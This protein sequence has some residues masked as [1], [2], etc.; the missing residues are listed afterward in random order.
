[1][2]ESINYYLS[3]DDN[4]YGEISSDVLDSESYGITLNVSRVG[5]SYVINGD[6]AQ[7]TYLSDKF[8]V[9]LDNIKEELRFIANYKFDNIVCCLSE[10]Q[11]GVYLD[12]KVHDKD[13]AY[14]TAGI[15]E[16]TGDYSVDE[17]K[18]AIHALIE[19]HPILKGRVLDTGYLPLL[20]CDSYP[21]ISITNVDDYSTLTRPFDLG[22]S[23]ARFFIVDNKYGMFIVYDMHHIISDATSRVIINRD[24]GLA[25]SGELD[26]K[27]D[28]G[29]VYASRDSFDSQFKPDYD[30]A[31]GFF[32]EMFADIDEVS[33]LLDDVDGCAGSVSLPIRGVREDILSFV[34]DKGITVSSFLNAVFAY[35]Y[36]RFIGGNKVYYTFTVNGRHEDYSQDAL[37]M[38]VRT[39]PILVDCTNASVG[40][41]LSGVSNLI[42][43]SMGNSVYPFRLLASEFG[44]SNSVSF[45]YN[46]DLNDTT[47][48]GDEIVFSDG[49]DSVSDLLCF[50]NDLDDGFL[51]SLN[52]DD[53]IS[54]DTAERFVNVFKEIL[55]QLL[56][57]ETLSDI[58]YISNDDVELLDSFNDTD[59]DLDYAD[60]L[61]AFNDNLSKYPDNPLV[62]F[63][64]ISYSYG[65]GAFIAFK[66]VELLKQAEVNV[67][68][69]V[70][71]VCGRSEWY[72]FSV[73]SVLSIGAVPVPIDNN[74]P[75]ERIEFMIKDS[76]SKVIITDNENYNH[77]NDLSNDSIFVNVSSIVEESIG[78][79]SYL[80]VVY[81][82]LAGILYTSGTTGIPKG[83]KITRKSVLNLAAHYA[84]AQNL[85]NGDIYAL[86]PSIGFDAGY[87][88]IFKVLYS[89]A[90]LVIIPED[91]KYDMDK[92]NEYLIGNNVGHVF[93]TTQVSKL[94]MQNVNNT[95]LK[96]LS[97]GGEKLG[98][99][100]SPENYIV[101][102]DYGPT[103]AF[104]FITSIDISQKTDDTSIG[105]LNYNSKAYILDQE[106][107]RVP[108]GAVGELYLAGHQ[109]ADGYLNREE[110]TVKSFVDN[111][112]DGSIMY[113]TGDMVR[114]LPDNTLSIVGRRDSQV[115]IR[116]NRV[117][118]GDVESVIRSINFVEDVTVQTVDN[119][120]NNELVAY[121]V[122]SDE[123]F[124]GNLRELVCD[125][126]AKHK[127]DYMVPSYVVRLD[128]VPLTVN[129]KVDKDALPEVDFDSLVVEYV[130]P[131][132]NDE[133]LIVDAFEKVFNLE[134]IGVYDDF[135]HLGGD[136]L[137]AIKLLTYLDGFN[138]SAGDILSLRTPYAIAN[139]VENISFDLNLYSLDE[140]CPLNEPQLN[141][142]LDIKANSKENSY[143]IPLF[144]NISARYDIND[145]KSALG[146]MFD[147]HPALGMCVSDDFDVPYLI[148]GS[149]PS[150]IV[151]SDVNNDFITQ[152]LTEPFDL[153]DSL[154]R[155]LIVEEED[156]FVIYAVFHHIIFD[157]LSSDVFKR[158]LH[159]ILVGGDVDLD[160]SFLMY[161][162]M[163]QDPP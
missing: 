134:N 28:L 145:I 67:D 83:V 20:I 72:L 122:V 84:D 61:D 51:V 135:I 117:E 94:F 156:G 124:E 158:D 139:N 142:Y 160:D 29:F 13:T 48:V 44:L 46:Y 43:E 12:E 64:N 89:G 7:N 71:F 73:L 116:G 8:S 49:A 146:V 34:H 6:Y 10:P 115:K 108:C 22:K 107:R 150:I 162:L 125:Y 78:T 19:K 14:S 50:V 132:T 121:V 110:E 42:L 81:G 103:E 31:Y 39:I 111:P 152:F 18:D 2:F 154:C 118:L 149:E 93:I 32:R 155:F 76:N 62:S 1:M 137:T 3:E 21:E 105:I 151:E 126:V 15:F 97:V 27:V 16:C 68:D 79:L 9:F 120:G 99:F 70:A 95:S 98:K 86:Y 138:I 45:E 5:D 140:G 88:S 25:L 66:I 47:S 104:A 106:G 131:R 109:I 101:M 56:D 38:F 54:Q 143:L 91:I 130:A 24:L 161:W 40:D 75:D 90:Q 41:F 65:E 52:H 35:T 159:T 133:R 100:E 153:H 57:K 58:D 114:M 82:N 128:E 53:I 141:V 85:T 26:G 92:L 119:N 144:M 11:L 37:G 17:L 36:S 30:A 123:E 80:P 74:L 77:L 87:K 147:A 59:H 127:Q 4:G 129:G 136:S 112:F 157:A 69:C 33:S 96:V 23:L 63:D 113:R 55:V 102:D 148:K 60:V 163:V